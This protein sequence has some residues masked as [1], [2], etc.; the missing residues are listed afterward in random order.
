MILKHEEYKIY[1]LLNDNSM[2][3]HSVKRKYNCKTR[4]V[5][6]KQN[7]FVIVVKFQENHT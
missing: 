4:G 1:I 3:L 5:K 6:S 7:I 2:L